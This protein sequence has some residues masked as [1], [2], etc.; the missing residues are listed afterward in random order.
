VV[1]RCS[2]SARWFADGVLL[3]E[4]VTDLAWQVGTSP[5]RAAAGRAGKVVP[6]GDRSIQSRADVARLAAALT[7]ASLPMQHRVVTA[8][9]LPNGVA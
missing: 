9:A 3:A 6:S 7:R 2:G 8:D 5:T 1:P 4:H